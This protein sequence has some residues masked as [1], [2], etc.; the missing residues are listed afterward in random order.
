MDIDAGTNHYTEF[1][2]II[3]IFFIIEISFSTLSENF[4]KRLAEYNSCRRTYT[5]IA[6]PDV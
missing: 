4:I 6:F 3:G 1:L 2:F 5:L